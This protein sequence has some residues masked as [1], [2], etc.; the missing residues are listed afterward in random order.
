M[1]E[2][3]FTPNDYLV[4]MEQQLKHDLILCKFFKQENEINKAKI[5]YNRINLLN[6]EINEL[7]QFIK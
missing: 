2:G 7:K 4:L 1:S 3:E 6:E 5:V